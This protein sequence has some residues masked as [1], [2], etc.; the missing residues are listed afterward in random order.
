MSQDDLCRELI[1]RWEKAQ[2]R[3]EEISPVELC[4]DRPDLLEAVKRQITVLQGLIKKWKEGQELREAISPTELCRDC[5]ELQEIAQRL[6]D[7][8]RFHERMDV[9]E[10]AQERGEEI[11]PEELCGDCPDLLE[12]V[13]QQIEAEGFVADDESGPKLQRFAHYTSIREVGKGGMGEVFLARDEKLRRKVA[14]KHIQEHL[15]RSP[16][17]RRLFLR[18]VEI[19]ARLQHPGVVPI[20]DLMRK[21]QPWYA[22]RFIKGPT[23]LKTIDRFHAAKH[24]R[25]DAAALHPLLRRFVAVCQTIAYAHSQGVIHRDIKPQNIVLGKFAETLVLD[26]G[27]AKRLAPKVPPESQPDVSSSAKSPAGEQQAVSPKP[28]APPEPKPAFTAHGMGTLDYAS[29]EQQGNDP[30][31]VGPASDIYSLGATL[32]HLLTGQPPRSPWLLPRQVKPEVPRALEAIC[33]KAMQ[34]RPEDRYA[35]ASALAAD[36]QDYLDD[37]PISAYREP[38]ATRAARWGRKHKTLVA[39]SFVLLTTAAIALAISTGLVKHEQILAENARQETV[40]ANANLAAALKT[41]E[42]HLYL[43]H[44]N[45]ASQALAEHNAA[46]MRELL[47]LYE[48]R[49]RQS[50]RRHLE[51]YFLWK[52]CHRASLVFVRRR[53][54]AS[55]PCRRTAQPLPRPARTTRFDFG[56]SRR[57]GSE[58]NCPATRAR[59]LLWHLP[60]LVGL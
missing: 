51:W 17:K 21:G 5:T 36:V 41:A 45:M 31:N 20:Y 33:L 24:P 25:R 1:D 56:I 28:T 4:R 42:D 39:G 29:P 43:A 48:P 6:I 35:T 3:R 50:D 34:R 38:L 40:Q 55:W 37:K 7:D 30:N 23:L 44:M 27:L 57:E 26:W 53:K 18:E 15:G 8:E 22:M 16:D 54:P 46:R 14:L 19:T 49:P 52:A 59:L 47:A 9:W 58:P 11:S 32:Y 2:N 12:R 60:M 13:K 10:E